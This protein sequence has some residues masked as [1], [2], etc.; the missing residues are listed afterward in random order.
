MSDP[1][2]P[3]AQVQVSAEADSPPLSQRPTAA[4]THKGSGLLTGS[5]DPKRLFPIEDPA[6]IAFSHDEITGAAAL[7]QARK[8]W[9]LKDGKAL[10]AV[11]PTPD[12]DEIA[13]DH[14]SLASR[15]LDEGNPT[16]TLRICS[17]VYRLGIAINPRL[18]QLASDAF[19][20]LQRFAEAET[21]ILQALQLGD[22]S[23]GVYNNLVNM[24]LMRG[25]VAMAG[26]YL[27]KLRELDPSSPLIPRLCDLVERATSTHG[28]S[29]KFSFQDFL[30]YIDVKQ[31]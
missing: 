19:L 5:S 29:S 27:R 7:Q 26:A 14:L 3:P 23:P 4:S 13:S 18:Y 30:N 21:C 24:A 31:A 8:Q 28:P 25:D 15:A 16:L 22:D 6:Q 17:H 9:K 11:L 10:A 2:S 1:S 12:P 20:R